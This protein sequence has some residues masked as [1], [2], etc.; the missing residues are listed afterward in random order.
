MTEEQAKQLS[1]PVDAKGRPMAP[2]AA[3]K[4]KAAETPAAA[5]PA[6]V[7]NGEPGKRSVRTVGPTFLPSN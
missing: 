5:A 6:P 1:Q 7:Q 3:P 4:G 2:K